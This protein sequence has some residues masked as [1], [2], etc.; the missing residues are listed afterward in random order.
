MTH[1]SDRLLDAAE[2]IDLD[3]S[4]PWFV[5]GVDAGHASTSRAEIAQEADDLDDLAHLG[6]FV[7]AVFVEL[8]DRIRVRQGEP[9]AVIAPLLGHHSTM[10]GRQ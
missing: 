9:H 5:V 4:D 6:K 10:A 3:G 7:A 2:L 8:V 1:V